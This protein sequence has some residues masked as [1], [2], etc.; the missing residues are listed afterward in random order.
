METQDQNKFVEIERSRIF[1]EYNRKMTELI[2]RL[3]ESIKELDD[4]TKNR[5]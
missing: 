1:D 4:A 2:D 3:E 5:E